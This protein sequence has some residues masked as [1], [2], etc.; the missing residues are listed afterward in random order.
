[1]RKIPSLQIADLVQL[2]PIALVNTVGHAAMVIAMCTKGGGAFT[3][4]IKAAEPVVAVVLGVAIFGTKKMP[5]LLGTLS[6]IPITYGVAYASTLGNFGNLSS[7]LTSLAAG[8]GM[9][10]NANFALRSIIK[11]ELPGDFKSRTGLDLAANEHACTTI[12]S[13]VMLVP[14]AFYMEADRLSAWVAQH[15]HSPEFLHS[16]GLNLAICGGC[17]YLYN[18]LQNDVLSMLGPVPTAV[19]NTLKRVAIFVGL[20]LF[21]PESKDF[22]EQKVLGCVIAVA[23][24]M[25]VR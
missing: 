10:S 15:Q 17:W 7:A 12:F 3:H 21:D 8:M 20:Y 14:V 23:G 9:L 5:S 19:G 16:A 1:L 13:M 24:C 22:P 2:F 18:E 4:V 6:L 11:K 25:A